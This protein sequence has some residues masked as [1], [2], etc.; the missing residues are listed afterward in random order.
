M[1]VDRLT[2][3][4]SAV[5]DF[6]SE[7]WYMAVLTVTNLDPLPPFS[8]KPLTDVSD[9]HS[10]TWAAVGP[11]RP[12][13]AG[14]YTDAPRFVPVNVTTDEPVPAEFALKIEL[15]CVTSTENTFVLLATRTPTVAYVRRDDNI[16][17]GPA[18]Q[19]SDVSALHAVAWHA[20][21]RILARAE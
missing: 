16:T 20:L 14:V 6:V 19:T 2:P 5:T 7:D 10:D 17:P 13:T 11:T 18:R 21:C 12:A 9:T 4:T 8:T 3:P 15:S 1:L